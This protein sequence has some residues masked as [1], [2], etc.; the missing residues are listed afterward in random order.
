[1]PRPGEIGAA[2]PIGENGS[3]GRAERWVAGAPA[4]RLVR[5]LFTDLDGTLLDRRLTLDPVDVEA[6][7]RA[8]QAGNLVGIATGRMYRSA[9]PYALQLQTRLPLICYQGALIQELPGEGAGEVL[10]RREVPAEVSRPVLELAHRR[11]Y[12]VNV[13][14]DD[15]LLVEAQNADVAFYT[16]VAQIEAV[17]ATDPPLEERLDRGSTK[18]T[19]VTA[20]LDRFPRLLAEV[21]ELVGDRAEVTRSLVGFCEITAKGVNKGEAL[22]WLCRHLGVAPQQTIALGDAPN[23]LPMLRAAGTAVAVEGA[24]E[25]VKAQASLVVP[26]PGRGGLAAALAQLGLDRDQA[27]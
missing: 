4:G 8:Q 23:D 26:G 20:D 17:V 3:C 5:L 7:H 6:A 13:Y 24:A 14:Q 18:M 11:G 1:M 10:Y 22:L 25:E 9:L 21:S 15:Q 27:S 19:L 16:S 12:S 2:L